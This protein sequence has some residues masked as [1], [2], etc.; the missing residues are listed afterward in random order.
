MDIVTGDSPPISQKSYTLPLKY[1]AWAH[2]GS[3]LLEKV[4]I[5]ANSVS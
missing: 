3:E 2:K 1:T 5:I 4:D